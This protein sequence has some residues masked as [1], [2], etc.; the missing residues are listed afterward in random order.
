MCDVRFCISAA[1]PTSRPTSDVMTGSG[2]ERPSASKAI[3]E[4]KLE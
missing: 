3:E 2:I 1:I 4:R